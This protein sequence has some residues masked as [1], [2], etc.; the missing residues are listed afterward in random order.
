MLPLVTVGFEVE[1]WLQNRLQV[2]QVVLMLL[3]VAAAH[4]QLWMALLLDSCSCHLFLLSTNP[5]FPCISHL[6]QHALCIPQT[7]LSLLVAATVYTS[8]IAFRQESQN[9]D[10][11]FYAWHMEEHAFWLNLYYST[12]ML[13]VNALLQIAADGGLQGAGFRNNSR[14]QV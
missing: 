1:N 11:I 4:G 13:K 5:R 12:W 9:W 10:W 3:T 14:N 2:L 8:N 6:R 7:Y